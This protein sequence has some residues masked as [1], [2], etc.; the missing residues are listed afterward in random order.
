MAASAAP[1]GQL[2]PP[3]PGPAGAATASDARILVIKL[4]DRLHNMRTL[5]HLPPATQVQTSRQTLEILMPLARQPGLGA[6]RSEL[7]DLLKLGGAEGI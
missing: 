4:A 5:R 3:R 1:G 7:E 2:A 6:I